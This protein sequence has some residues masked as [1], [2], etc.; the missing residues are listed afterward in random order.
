M[1]TLV[2]AHRVQVA[3]D[4]HQQESDELDVHQEYQENRWDHQY[5]QIHSL[6]HMVR[7]HLPALEVDR[8]HDL[9]Q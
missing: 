7:C 9:I 1:H 3:Q 8:L 4:Q 2:V 6:I 5:Y